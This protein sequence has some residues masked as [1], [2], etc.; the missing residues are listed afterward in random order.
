LADEKKV[1]VKNFLKVERNIYSW[2]SS[3]KSAAEQGVTFVTK[4]KL[5]EKLRVGQAE[6]GA[7]RW[8]AQKKGEKKKKKKK[9]KKWKK[10]ATRKK[11]KPRQK[12]T[13]KTNQKRGFEQ[14]LKCWGVF[15]C[16]GWV[17]PQQRNPQNHPN[18]K[19]PPHTKKTPPLPVW[20]KGVWAAHV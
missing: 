12:N 19:N 8:A 15:F 16:S 3:R 7:P 13:Q 10:K 14:N 2:R 6:E 20:F 5:R 11:R 4:A 9:K 1:D 17:V 18:Q